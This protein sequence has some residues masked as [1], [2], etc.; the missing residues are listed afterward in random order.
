MIESKDVLA[1]PNWLPHGYDAANR[2][3][4]FALIPPAMREQLTF[5][6]D[7]KPSSER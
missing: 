6:A 1:D 5:L 3:V 7:F 2:R 4:A